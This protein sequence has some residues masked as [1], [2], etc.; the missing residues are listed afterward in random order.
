MDRDKDFRRKARQFVID[1][2]TEF[3]GKKPSEQV[4]D[5]TVENL[6]K[7]FASVVHEPEST[8]AAAAAQGKVTPY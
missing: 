4:V 6:V 7:A 8:Q 3:A 2:L 1:A 5:S